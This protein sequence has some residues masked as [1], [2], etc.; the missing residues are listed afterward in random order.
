MHILSLGHCLQLVAD[1]SRS[2]T[3]QIYFQWDILNKAENLFKQ[4]AAGKVW[5]SIIVIIEYTQKLLQYK[6]TQVLAFKAKIL[7]SEA[8]KPEHIA[9]RI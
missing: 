4:M 1:R 2:I 5:W 7:M 6:E 3:D 9:T 8:I